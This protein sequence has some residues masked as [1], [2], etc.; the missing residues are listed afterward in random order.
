MESKALIERV[1]VYEVKGEVISRRNGFMCESYDAISGRP[2]LLNVWTHVMLDDDV[3]MHFE[4]HTQKLMDLQHPNI[5]GILN[6]G[7]DREQQLAYWVMPYVGA[8]FL[9]QRLGTPWPIAD[10]VRIAAEIAR[11]LDYALQ[12]GVVHGAVCPENVLLTERGWV[13]MLDFGM[14]QFVEE[15]SDAVLRS[16]CSPECIQGITMQPASDLYAV[17]VILYEMLSGQVPFG[18]EH[19]ES[20]LA[21]QEQNLR[22]LRK[23]RSDVPREIDA[24]L[25]QLLASDP[26][27]RFRDSAT[28]ARA[29]VDALPS[30]ASKSSRPITPPPNV[31]RPLSNSSRQKPPR[32][33]TSAV[34]WP[35]FGSTL[36]CIMRWLLGKIAV[37][38]VVLVLICA[39]LAVGATFLLSSV[40]ERRL[41]TYHWRLEGWERGG[42]SY[43][44]EE[45]INTPLQQVVEPY[46]L[47]ALTD[48]R[49]DFY[50]PDI[51]E[52]QGY[53]QS[54]PI[55]FTLGL[56]VDEGVPQIELRKFNDVTL[57]LIGGIISDGM[58]R[59]M[60]ASWQEVPVRL[61]VFQVEN[62]GIEVFLVPIRSQGGGQ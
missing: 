17:G 10:A 57:Y 60:K 62:D 8:T 3:C 23:T 31:S 7:I 19:S 36:W 48:L 55:S 2:V 41:A 20:G 21:Y 22:P 61:S 27:E 32:T 4:Q 6:H 45:Y 50:A 38:L 53:F 11:A 24:I 14:I 5:L 1:G 56:Y 59:G 39:A 26:Q 43:I 28:L 40:L 52:L 33:S 49:V 58:N 15:T 29:L 34:F 37:A 42:R 13:L 44:L 46:T 54:Q 51:V 9:E 12:K 47:G 35:K 30:E 16:Y 25:A 18:V